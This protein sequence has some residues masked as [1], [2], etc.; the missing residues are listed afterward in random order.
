M[1]TLNVRNL[2]PQTH[3]ALRVRAAQHRRSTEAEVRAILDEAVNPPD[4][5]GLGSM[6]RA[7]AEEFGGVDLDVT[8]DNPPPDPAVF[9]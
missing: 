9:E 3:H 8:R 6:L 5:V 4:H 2:S 1:P 7:I